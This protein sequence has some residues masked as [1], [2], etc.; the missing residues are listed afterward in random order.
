MVF[1]IRFSN[2]PAKIHILRED[3][4]SIHKQQPGIIQQAA[5]SLYF[6]DCI[7]VGDYN[8]TYCSVTDAD[9]GFQFMAIYDTVLVLTTPREY[10]KTC[11]D[12]WDEDSI[13]WEPKLESVLEL[14]DNDAE[15]LSGFDH[16]TSTHFPAAADNLRI[17][18]PSNTTASEKSQVT[19]TG[20]AYAIVDIERQKL[21]WK[22]AGCSEEVIAVRSSRLYDI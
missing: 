14:D 2:S 10:R 6:E 4:L 19:G 22:M 17:A 13:K 1:G 16:L 15:Q 5:D 20:E 21:D 9:M 11:G 12:Y 3:I 7:Q 18:I 8:K